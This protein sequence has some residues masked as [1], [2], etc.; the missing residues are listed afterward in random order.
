MYWERKVLPIYSRSIEEV[1]KSYVRG[2]VGQRK[3]EKASDFLR[4]PIHLGIQALYLLLQIYN[5]LMVQTFD[6]T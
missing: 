3:N 5:G 6:K 2:I 4:L 1:E